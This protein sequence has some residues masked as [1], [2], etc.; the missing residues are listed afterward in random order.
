MRGEGPRGRD[1]GCV[2]EP[3]D[4]KDFCDFGTFYL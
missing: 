1:F 4:G 3:V 2:R